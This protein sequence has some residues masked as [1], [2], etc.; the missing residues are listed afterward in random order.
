[1]WKTRHQYDD[2]YKKNAVKLSYGSNKT[3]KEIAGDLGISVSLLYRWRKKYTSEGEKTQ[4]AT[5]EEENRA[6][7]LENAELSVTY[8]KAAA[9]FA[10]NQK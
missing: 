1:M 3:V 2:E 9:C 6:L 4:F 7:K 5:M 10:K 8:K